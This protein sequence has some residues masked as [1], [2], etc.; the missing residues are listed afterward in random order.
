MGSEMCI[1]DS[2]VVAL[3]QLRKSLVDE[4]LRFSVKCGSCFVQ[5]QDVGVLQQCTRD[6]Y[7]L[8]LSTGE[9]CATGTTEGLEAVGLKR[10]SALI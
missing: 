4:S 2:R 5:Y 9:L 6:R 7:A 1:R 8:L 10:R 3:E